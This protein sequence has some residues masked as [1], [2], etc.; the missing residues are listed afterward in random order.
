VV[1]TSG[2]NLLGSTYHFIKSDLN[3][4]GFGNLVF[5]Y[6]NNYAKNFRVYLRRELFEIKYYGHT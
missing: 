6:E 2:E 3:C 4:F 5:G 1:S